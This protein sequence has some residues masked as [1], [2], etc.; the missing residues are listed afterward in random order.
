MWTHCDWWEPNRGGFACGGYLHGVF[1]EVRTADGWGW[2]AVVG[3]TRG[4]A[5]GTPIGAIQSAAN[6]A[7]VEVSAVAR[8]V[9]GL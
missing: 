4:I 2:R 3:S 1:V 5:W 7:L 9:D 6:A 8:A